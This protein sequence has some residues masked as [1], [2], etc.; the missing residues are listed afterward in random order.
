MDENPSVLHL[1]TT[2]AWGGLEMYVFDLVLKMT[3][4]GIRCAVYCL[5]NTVIDQKFK[6]ARII[7]FPAFKHSKY[8]ILDIF[9]VREIIKKEDFQ[10]IH[11][12]TNVDVWRG[13]L[14]LTFDSRRKLIF[15]LYMGV[16]KKKDLIHK[17][18][19]KN[20]SALVSTSEIINNEVKE[21]YPI[22]HSKIKLIRYG[23]DIES[24]V[25]SPSKR[26]EIRNE[27]KVGQNEIVIG[28]MC[29]IDLQKGVKEFAESYLQIPENDR[30]N[31]KYWIIGDPT[32]L[33]KDETG[34][35]IY[36]KEAEET[37]DYLISFINKN[38]LSEKIILIPFQPDMISFLGAL[39]VFVLASYNEMYSLAVLDA[40]L[41]NLPVISTNKGGTPEQLGF[42]ERG[43]LVEPKSSKA[44]ADQITYCINNLIETKEKAKK[45]FNWT[46]TQ[47]NW[48]NVIKQYINL[49]HEVYKK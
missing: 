7:T 34:E 30:K 26:E 19:F 8:N 32:I 5:P 45:G 16:V 41:L 43:F 46:R 29:R 28:T 12:H 14:A 42:G 25:V 44:L 21:K 31:L 15:N 9:K 17:F 27:Y 40:M 24:Y 37:N 4:A 1:L 20:I 3:H 18:I 48:K 35:I 2:Q 49:Y 38:N 23:R 47:H 6:E 33:K 11:A 10:I 36:E 22:S 13:S 39:D